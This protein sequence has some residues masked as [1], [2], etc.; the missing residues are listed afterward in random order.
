MSTLTL[1]GRTLTKSSTGSSSSRRSF[2]TSAIVAQP[3]GFFTRP[4]EAPKSGLPR[5]TRKTAV[6][7]PHTPPNIPATQAPNTKEVWSPSQ[8]PRDL[9]MRGP[10]FEQINYELQPLPLAGMEMI[11]REPIRL[12]PKRIISCDGGEMKISACCMTLKLVY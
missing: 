10:R 9:A 12:T 3:I 4:P 2:S 1:L 6:A 11:S 5:V 8:N 7:Q